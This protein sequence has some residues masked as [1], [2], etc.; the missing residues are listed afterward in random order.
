[1]LANLETFN[2]AGAIIMQDALAGGTGPVAGDVLQITGGVD[3]PAN[4]VSNGGTLAVDTVLNEGGAASLSDV[5]MLDMATLGTGAT[6][7]S[8]ANAGGLGAQTVDNGILIVDV[9]DPAASAAGA[10]ALNDF[11]HR[12]RLSVPI[13]PRRRR[14][15]GGE[16]RR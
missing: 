12:R 4:F 8:I 14:D 6:T 2:H 15:A 3:G 11:V 16:R 13:V 5:L 7:L 9:A 10:F 1:M